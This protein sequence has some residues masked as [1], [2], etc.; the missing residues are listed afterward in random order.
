MTLPA[1]TRL[2][3]FQIV[4]MI[5]QGGMG[6]VYRARDTQLDRDV[7]LKVLPDA[8]A[9]DAERLHRFEREAKALAALNHPNIAQVFGIVT[10]EGRRAPAIAMEFVDGRGLDEIK[11]AMPLEELLP[12]LR[13]IAAALEAAHDSGIIHRDLK[14]ANVRLKEDGTV[15]V[16]DFGLAKAFDPGTGARAGSEDPASMATITSPATGLGIILGTA[17]YMSPEQARGKVV[18]RRADI[19]AFGVVAFELVTGSRLFGGETVSDTIAS[20]LRQD[21][22]WDRLPPGTP[23][24]FQRLLRHCLDRDPRNRLKDAGDIRIELDDLIGSK[25]SDEAVLGAVAVGRHVAA[26]LKRRMFTGWALGILIGIGAGWWLGASRPSQS[27]VPWAQFT[28]ITDEAG[29]EQS[30]SI[31]PDGDSV[32]YESNVAGNWDIYVRR[33][34][35]R[36]ATR[37]AGDP[38]RNEGAPA[39]SPD[40]KSIAFHEADANGGIFIVG[41]TGES[42]HRVSDAGFHPAWSP[43][44][45]SIA[46]CDER[47]IIPRSRVTTSGMSVVDVASGAVRV[48]TKGDAVQPAWSPSGTRLAYWGNVNGQRDIYTIAAAG[49]DPVKVTD[50]PALDWSVVWAPD[51]RHLYFA[52]DR[53]GTFNL[54]RIPI[55]ESSGR[56]TG[57]PEPVTIGVVA[58]VSSPSFSRDGLKLVFGSSIGTVNPVALP[59][60]AGEKVGEP[61]FLFR[62]DGT[63]SPSSVSPDGSM[64]A[65][66]GVGRTEDVWVSRVDG[67]SLRRLTDDAHNDRVPIWLDD[68]VL[69]FYS[70]RGGKYE[71]WT[72]RKD[73][74][75]LTQVSSEPKETL[76]WAFPDP[77]GHR[78]WAYS[79]AGSRL[80]YTYPLGQ[81]TPQPGVAMPVIKV[82]GGILR[83]HAIT[84][85]GKWLAGLA[86][87]TAG[88]RLGVGWHNLETGE[89]WVSREGSDFGLPAWLDQ[90]RIVFAVD[91][92]LAVV[93]TAKRRRIIGGPFAFELNNALIPAVSPDARTVFVGGGTTEADVWMVE[94]KK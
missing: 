16:L 68:D 27:E 38:A 55:D 78:V 60:D 1:G 91:G 41:A 79:G 77:A 72:I 51:G 37:V 85:D 86:M 21:V 33:I 61:R 94:R 20:V 82:D 30:P 39:F 14:P 22:P 23:L 69:L 65:M 19:W 3:S 18:D 93:D 46:F 15:K 62:Q 29:R 9:D 34:G 49:G 43:D 76:N 88:A 11:G 26:N 48:L 12:I 92:R 17:A 73:G 57:A 47:I 84:R 6:E 4:S 8:F 80:S 75:G 5:G 89:T 40:G 53:G 36:N 64:L 87:S 25:V 31:S 35:G 24:R 63:F 70:N 74:S 56:A 90:Q 50:D 81:K 45:R 7:A 2:G 44:G 32:A 58:N 13:Q 54:W 71:V 42:E 67:T 66:F 83:P 28:Q 52:S 10:A 59:L